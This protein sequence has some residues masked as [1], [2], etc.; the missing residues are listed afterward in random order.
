MSWA[1]RRQLLYLLG[2]FAFGALVVFAILYPTL[3]KEP[4]CFDNK[5][6]GTETGLDCGG[7]CQRMCLDDTSA[8]KILWS[9][10]FPVINDTYNLVAFIE[11]QNKDAGV[12]QVDYEFKVYD[13]NN[14][15]IGIR[16]GTTYIPP[17]QQFAIF[18][19][20]FEAGQSTIKSVSFD[21]IGDIVWLK[22]SPIIQTLPIRAEQISMSEDLTS[23]SLEA[24]IRNDSIYDMPPFDV[25]AILYDA[26]RNAITASKTRSEGLYS[27]TS[28]PVFFTWPQAFTQNVATKDVLIQINPFETEF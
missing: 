28:S 11:N 8:P 13:A 5:K 18:E 16:R 4:T 23:P 15:I 10:A 26:E 9:R 22:K 25:I 1:L 6:N 14:L 2:L 3:N 20:R 19:S 17:N 7:S 27:N 21:F 24:L 12:A